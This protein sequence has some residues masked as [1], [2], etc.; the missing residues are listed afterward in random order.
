LPLQIVAM[1]LGLPLSVAEFTPGRQRLVQQAVA[2]AAEVA[3][4]KVKLGTAEPAARRRLLA[5]GITVRFR[6]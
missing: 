5:A 3:T 6:V 2:K 4:S 1:A